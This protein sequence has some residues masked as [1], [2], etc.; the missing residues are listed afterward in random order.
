M[1]I[2]NHFTLQLVP[3][4]FDMVMLN[5]DDYHIYFAEELVKIKDL[6]LD[7][8][9]VGKKGVEAFQWTSKVTLLNIKHLESGALA[10]IIDI[11]LIGD[12]IQANLAV[13]GDAVFLHYLIDALKHED[14][15]RVIGLHTLVND[16]GKLGIVSDKEPR[17][18]TD[19]VTAHTRARLE[20][21]H[22][23]VHVAYL[24]NFVHIHIVV[25]ADTTELIGKSNVYSTVGVFHHL[26]HLS[27]ANVGNDYFALTEGGI[28]LL[29]FLANLFIVSTDGAVVVQQ[30][31]DHIAGD[32]SFGS[33]NEVEIF[34]NFE[35][36]SL[37]DGAH[38]LVDGAGTDG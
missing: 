14:R 19:A 7:D 26:G 30:L 20:N 32:D 24:D 35:T 25:T 6:V 17:V 12:A 36:I 27:S 3:V 34:T 5:H 11:L 29:N 22:A 13:V 23:W 9:F 38:E 1:A 37:N 15:L 2:K 21:V 31:I 28:I 4:L 10:Y 8:F 18:D 16:L 33:M